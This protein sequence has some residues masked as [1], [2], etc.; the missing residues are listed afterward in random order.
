MELGERNIVLCNA[1]GRVY[2]LE[3]RCPHADAKLSLGRL[4]GSLLECPFHGGKIDVRDGSTQ[5]PP[6]RRAA[7]T[8]PVREVDGGFEIRFET[9]LGA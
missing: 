4:E 7:V 1:E 8:F 5:R 6:I 2:A 3:D 9:E